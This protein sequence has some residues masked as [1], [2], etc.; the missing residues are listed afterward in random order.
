MSRS[1]TAT[2][3]LLF[4]PNFSNLQITFVDTGMVKAD[5]YH[6]PMDTLA[7]LTLHKSTHCNEHHMASIVGDYS[8]LHIIFCKITAGFRYTVTHQQTVL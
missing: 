1:V 7:D 5:V 2:F 4:L 8:I 3:L 6:P